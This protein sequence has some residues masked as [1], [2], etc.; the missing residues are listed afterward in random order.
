MNDTKI[1]DSCFGFQT[2]KPIH[3]EGKVITSIVSLYLSIPLSILA[4][5][6]NGLILHAVF[7]TNSLQKPSNLLLAFIAITDLL[8]GVLPMPM[9]VAI[10]ILEA[11][12]ALTPCTLRV[13]SRLIVVSLTTLSFL[14]MGSLSI[15]CLLACSFPTK[16]RTW[17][18]KKIY[19]WIF[20]MSWFIPV[21]LFTL[22]IAKIIEPDIGR[23]CLSVILFVNVIC[24]V[25]SNLRTYAIIRA[26]NSSVGDIL[27]Q[28]AAEQRR[29][30]QKRLLNTLVMVTSF[31]LACNLPNIIVLLFQLNEE[32]SAFYHTFRYSSVLTFLNSA[33]NPILF[34]YRKEDIRRVVLQTLFTLISMLRKGHRTTMVEPQI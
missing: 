14:T 9:T 22:S 1:I 29:K 4:T 10:R 17:Q 31:F 19:G 13:T 28:A 16:Y 32:S 11:T 24:I 33:L 3:S 27:S 5:I 6:G 23:R 15:D 26:Q 2:S 25:L 34:C 30:K 7:T 21:L 12:K 18:L 8:T 20:A